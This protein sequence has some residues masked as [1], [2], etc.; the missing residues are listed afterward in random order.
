MSDIAARLD[1]AQARLKSTTERPPVS[2]EPP[3][4]S[5]RTKDP[6]YVVFAQDEEKL[7]MLLTPTPIKASSRKA[8][9]VAAAPDE[10]GTFF[11]VPAEQFKPLTR[12][13]R[14]MTVD[15]FE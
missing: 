8:A 9:I 12:T 10:G 1:D 7:W 5:K 3:P 4:V 13:V 6:S 15:A 14:Q 2:D 11:V